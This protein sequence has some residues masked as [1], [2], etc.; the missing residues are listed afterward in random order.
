MCVES[1]T[2]FPAAAS[3]RTGIWVREGCRA[4]FDVPRAY[5]S[6]RGWSSQR[7]YGR[8]FR[9]GTQ[10]NDGV[11]ERVVCEAKGKARVVCPVEG[12]KNVVTGLYQMLLYR[13]R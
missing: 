7:G 2:H 3:D 1:S 4:D 11:A 12:I 9:D 6:G 10:E 5:S 8:Y 13:S